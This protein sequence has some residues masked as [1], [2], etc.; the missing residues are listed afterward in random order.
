MI[1]PRNAGSKF[2]TDWYA[3]AQLPP[4]HMLVAWLLLLSQTWAFNYFVRRSDGS[5]LVSKRAWS[6]SYLVWTTEQMSEMSILQTEWTSDQIS[7]NYVHRGIT[8]KLFCTKAHK[9]SESPRRCLFGNERKAISGNE[10]LEKLTGTSFTLVLS[11][12]RW[13][14]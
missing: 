1:W 2:S 4:Y 13:K 11:K 7:T 12:N 10:A 3:A 8:R 14:D 9:R 5:E 6:S